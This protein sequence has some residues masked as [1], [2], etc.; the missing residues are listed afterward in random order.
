LYQKLKS[1]RI[2]WTSEANQIQDD[3]LHPNI[4][5]SPIYYP[6]TY[7]G[8]WNEY[9]LFFSN[10][11]ECFQLRRIQKRRICGDELASRRSRRARLLLHGRLR[12]R[13]WRFHLPFF[14]FSVYLNY[15]FI[16]FIFIIFIN[17]IKTIK[18][19]IKYFQCKFL[20]M[21]F[22][23]WKKKPFLRNNGRSSYIVLRA[24]VR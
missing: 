1:Y 17:F 15:I 12:L 9:K 24:S 18:K 2:L 14:R 13:R 16:N 22:L 7:L 10:S 5:F 19:K 3:F 23:K 21:V 20:I 8:K 6:S 11:S 4:Q